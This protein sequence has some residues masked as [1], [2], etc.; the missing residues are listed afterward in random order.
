MR[1]L[2]FLLSLLFVADIVAAQARSPYLQSAA[3][4]EITVVWRTDSPGQG[5][6]CYGTSSSSLGSMAMG[7]ASVTQHEVRLTGLSPDTRYYYAATTGGCPREADPGDTF[8]TPPTPGTTRPFRMWVV[9]DSGTGDRRQAEVRDAMLGFVGSARPDLFIHV[10]DM[11]YSDGTDQEFTR[12]FYDV[13]ADLLRNMICWPALGNHEGHSSMSATESGPYYEGFVLP[14]DGRSGGLSSGTEAY[15][16]F[17]HA[18]VHFVVLDS[19]QSSRSPTGPMLTW[20]DEDLAATDQ[21]WIVAFWHHPPYTKGSHDSDREG[22]LTEMRENALPILDSHG[23]DL[24]LGGHSHIYERSYLVHGAYDT[25]TT[26]A[27]FI[28]DTGDGR[29]DGDGAYDMAGPGAVYIVAGHGGTGLR[30]PGDHP[31]MYL[32]E[33]RNGSVLIDVNGGMMTVRNIRHDGAVS[34]EFT[35]VKGEG[36]YLLAPVGGETFASGS[37][38]DIRWSAVGAVVPSIDIDYSIDGGTTWFPVVTGTENDGHHAWLT[39]LV[40][41]TEAVVRIRDSADASVMD[42]SG[43]FALSNRVEVELV[44]FGATWEY[45]DG[46][47]APAADWRTRLG[48]WP[49]GPAQLGYGDGDE[50]TELRD[51]DPNIPTVY[52]RRGVTIDGDVDEARLDV[53]FDD[54]IAVWINDRM[55]YGTN[56]DAGLG[57]DS[58]ASARSSDNQRESTAVDPSVF[59]RGENIVA[60]LVKQGSASSSDL[61]FDLRIAGRVSVSLPPPGDGGVPPTPDAGPDAEVP[62]DA[63]RLTDAGAPGD[64]GSGCGCRATRAKGSMLPLLLVLWFVRRRSTGV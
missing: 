33:L 24:V 6:V 3:P 31:L 4:T 9:G 16:S 15:Y 27:G 57:H 50:A 22:S 64:G 47:D 60:A 49:S 62:V 8:L 26:A 63:A 39:P 58:Y 19:H 51:E 56:V 61:S 59:V 54:A 36:L 5:R 30:G 21:Q 20:L 35:M 40:A 34:D 52:F 32:S 23:V 38:V 14:R 11:A 48:G 10:G 46:P 45:S 17:D 29:A 43:L 28:V 1:L 13:Y 42:Q 41:T 25:P 2:P 7:A 37:G 18:N 53:L 44:P 55:V 12:N